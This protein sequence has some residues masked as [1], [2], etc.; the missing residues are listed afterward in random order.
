MLLTNVQEP[1]TCIA[2][3]VEPDAVEG[4]STGIAVHQTRDV[5]SVVVQHG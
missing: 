2:L 4:A 1:V 3:K 5:P